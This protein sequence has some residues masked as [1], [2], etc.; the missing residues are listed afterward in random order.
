MAWPH[1]Q[2]AGRNP[3]CQN[4]LQLTQSTKVGR[5]CKAVAESLGVHTA[6]GHEHSEYQEF[7]PNVTLLYLLCIVD[8]FILTVLFYVPKYGPQ[9]AITTI[10]MCS[11][12]FIFCIV[13]ML[14]CIVPE[15]CHQKKF[16]SERLSFIFSVFSIIIQIL[17]L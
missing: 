16:I 11:R 15:M 12:C 2:Q 8:A 9:L 13:I 14:N 5:P 17:K 4:T 1:Q 7:R 10:L 6:R 3:N